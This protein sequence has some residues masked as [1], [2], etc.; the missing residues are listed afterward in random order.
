MNVFSVQCLHNSKGLCP[1]I[2]VYYFS[3]IKTHVTHISEIM[4][5][6]GSLLYKHSNNNLIEDKGLK[7]I[8]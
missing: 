6:I 8:L 2:P 4:I 5:Q 1:L 3:N 7:K